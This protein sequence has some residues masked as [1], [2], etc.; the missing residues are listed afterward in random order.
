MG[1][2][3]GS[4][5]AMTKTYK[6]LFVTTLL[7]FGINGPSFAQTAQSSDRRAFFGDLHLHTGYSFDA[8]AL[9]ATQT[10]PDDAYRF[11][12][13]QAVTMMGKPIKRSWPLDFL[14]VTDHSE[15]MGV[16]NQLDDPNSDFA[17][18]ELG[19][20]I[21]KDRNSAF[22]IL[23]TAAQKRENLADLHAKPA[24]ASAWERQVQAANQN[25]APGTFTTFIAYE[26]SSMVDGKYNLH[27]N[28]IFN[29]D[30]APQPFTSTDSLRPEDLWT[31]LE[32][33]RAS[34][35]D[36]LAIPHN[37]NASNGLMFDWNN[38][39]GKRIDQNYAQ[40]RA[41]NEPLVEVSQ[42]KGQ[43]ETTP[44]LSPNDEFANFE[45][46]DTLLTQ[47]NVKGKQNGSYIREAYGRGLVLAQETGTN[48]FKFGLV[49][50][51]D[52]HNGLSSSDENAYAGSAGAINPNDDG[53]DEDTA[54][55][56]LGLIETLAVID[57]E[58]AHTGAKPAKN[59]P[60][61][62]GTGNLTG[63]W[64]EENTR[65]SIYAALKRKETFGTSGTRLRVRMFGGWG[66]DPQSLASPDWAKMAYRNAVPMGSDLPTRTASGGP[67][68]L[69][70]AIKDPDGANLDR[71]QVVK[72]YLS[73][74]EPKEQ[75]FDAVWQPGR[76][77]NAKSGKLEP[78]GTSVNLKTATYTNTIGAAQL[79][80]VWRDPSFDPKQPAVYYL[81]ALE[82]PT[83]RWTTLLAARH[84]LPL[85]TAR[86]PVVQERA[87]SSP[88]WYTP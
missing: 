72:V 33:T 6:L 36:V 35:I 27:R 78:I 15:N 32:K 45:I 51:S 86:S 65:D 26:W 83:P 82:I 18:S 74:G 81:R 23:R 70:E 38:S 85:P 56:R 67:S 42:N 20:R 13:G 41:L 37:P 68:F 80:G 69:L 1:A 84:K 17:K 2:D 24:M 57:D 21:L 60:T 64:A 76:R 49:G 71:I 34:G 25:Y 63:V 53:L 88:I 52:F 28:V 31:Y 22:Y 54:K 40:R 4:I 5:T 3:E 30:H 14:A 39:D 58:A 44:Q 77:V 66:L 75:V 59:D 79:R 48:P 7:A 19:Q 87:W 16:M 29:S 9:F 47:R 8:W 55:K 11:A 50:A 46:Y 12:K 62:S 73:G 61:I 43:S 10:S